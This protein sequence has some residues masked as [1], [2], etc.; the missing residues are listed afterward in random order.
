MKA[1]SEDGEIG[2]LADRAAAA[3]AALP[4]PRQEVFRLVRQCGLSYGEVTSV[5]GI[6]HETVAVQMSLALA[7]LRQALAT[8][9]VASRV[10]TSAT[11][12]DA[13]GRAR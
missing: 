12:P 10:V 13:P 3:V 4:A 9:P 6:S 8:D 2:P 1:M 5:M 11:G 7:S